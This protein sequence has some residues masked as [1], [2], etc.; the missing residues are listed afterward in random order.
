MAKCG[1]RR[2][3]R[4]LGVGIL[5]A[6]EAEAAVDARH[7]GGLPGRHSVQAGAKKRSSCSASPITGLSCTCSR[8]R[9]RRSCEHPDSSCTRHSRTATGG[10]AVCSGPAPGHLSTDQR[11]TLILRYWPVGFVVLA[12]WIGR[13]GSAYEIGERPMPVRTAHAAISERLDM[14]SLRKML[15]TCTEAVFVEM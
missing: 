9:S 15:D 11:T 4:L 13:T 14:A 3:H 7:P 2:L 6:D 8:P 12:Y 5:R 1:A 10:R